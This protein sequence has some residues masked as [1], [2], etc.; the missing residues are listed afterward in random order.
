MEERGLR[1]G[2]ERRELRASDALGAAG[3]RLPPA[4]SPPA[5]LTAPPHHSLS[6][7]VHI[8]LSLSFFCLAICA[9]FFLCLHTPFVLPACLNCISLSISVR[10]C[11]LGQRWGAVS[12]FLI[13]F[14]PLLHSYFYTHSQRLSFFL[15][16]CVCM[17]VFLYLSLFMYVSA[18]TS[19]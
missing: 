13:L 10:M 18:F 19:L 15:S 11:A 9:F 16:V 12:I 8:N 6:L 1:T 5:S 17:Y 3:S 2:E 14:M 7:W 4:P